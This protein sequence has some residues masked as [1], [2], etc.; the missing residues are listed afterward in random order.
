M[1]RLFDFHVHSSHSDGSVSLA[2]RGRAGALRPH[3]I[4]DHFPYGRHF[5]TD[6]DVLRYLDQAARLGL[7][8]GLEYDLGVAPELRPRTR[9]AL[10]YLIGSVHQ[11]FRGRERVGYDL[12]GDFLKNGR[13]G[14]YVERDR[15]ADPTLRALILERTLELVRK[16]SERQGIAIVGHPTFTPLA[17]L[18][19]PEDAYPLE[20]QERLIA[21][22]LKLGLA[23]EVNEK[24]GVPHTAFLV[25]AKRAGCRF[26]VG[27]D[28]HG[29]LEPLDRTEAMIAAA[30]LDPG[31]FVW[32][33]APA[34]GR[35]P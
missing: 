17:A 2:D 32:P 22:C 20:W 35:A 33:T 29:P 10:D 25:R 12:A 5:Q 9:D 1:S 16:G 27:S 8:V 6:D 28:A 31:A 11:I 19:D 14:T 26:S 24:Y 15:F 34:A 7:R 30:A 18:G 23:V 4:S 3:G 13:R 21:L